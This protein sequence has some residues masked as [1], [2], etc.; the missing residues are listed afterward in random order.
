MGSLDTTPAIARETLWAY[1]G[2]SEE[3]IEK[4][5][6]HALEERVALEIACRFPA[7]ECIWVG[8][9]IRLRVGSYVIQ[10]RLTNIEPLLANQVGTTTKF[11]AR[12]RV[13]S[14]DEGQDVSNFLAEI[15]RYPNDRMEAVFN[16]LV[17]LDAVKIDMV[18]KLNLLLQPSYLTEWLDDK[19][20]EN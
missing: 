20:G 17:G 12:Y 10:A 7:N 5:F 16:S 8:R 14:K 3:N 11:L 15:I 2:V 1:T 13:R 9:E 19:Y 6:F 4:D 18:R